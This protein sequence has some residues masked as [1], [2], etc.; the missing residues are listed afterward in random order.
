MAFPFRFDPATGGLAMTSAED[1]IRQS[2]SII[3]STRPGERQMLP[4]FGCR[5]HELL[6]APQTQSTSARARAFVQEALA[7]WEPRIKVESVEAKPAHSGALQIRVEYKI[8]ATNRLA[9][10]AGLIAPTG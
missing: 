10:F 3:L 6:F 4:K 5:V 7:R 8:V 2:I 9:T 1:N